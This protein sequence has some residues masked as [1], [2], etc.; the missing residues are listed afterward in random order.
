[1][2]QIKDLIQ[3]QPRCVSGR[4]HSYLFFMGI[5]LDKGSDLC[6]IDRFPIAQSD[7]L[8]KGEDQVERV[9]H[10]LALVHGAAVLGNLKR[11]KNHSGL[12]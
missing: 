10:D 3:E 2:F 5:H 11:K 6:K 12:N 1:M 8:V 4:L 9:V 7:D